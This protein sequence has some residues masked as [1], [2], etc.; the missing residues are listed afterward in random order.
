MVRASVVSIFTV[1]IAMLL[2]GC[3]S[4]S[5]QPS[6]PTANQKQTAS[7]TAATGGNVWRMKKA[8][9]HTQI[10]WDPMPQWGIDGRPIQQ[11]VAMSMMVPTD[12]TFQGGPVDLGPPDCNLNTGRL[13]FVAFSPDK[14]TG[15]VS[16]PAIASVWSNDQRVLQVIAANNQQFQKMQ[17]CKIEQPGPLANKIAGIAQAMGGNGVQI[18][19][20]MEPIPGTAEKLA[21]LVQKANANL[22][23]QAAQTGAPAA[24]LVV[25]AGR[26]LTRGKDESGQPSEGYVA[27]MQVT[28]VDTLA[29]G[30]TFWTTDY[31]MQVATFAPAGM[32]AG[33][34]RMFSAMLDSVWVNPVYQES[35]AEVS[36]NLLRIQ[37]LTKQRLNQIAANM[38]ADNANAARQQQAI[39]MG[40]QNYAN[41]VHSNVAA[42]RSAALEHSSQQFSMYMGDQA[43]YHDPS[44][45]QNVQLSSQYGH[46]WA[47]NTGNTNEYILTDSP[48]YNPN[49]QVGSGSWTQ[50][51][52]V[53]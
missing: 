50:M 29:N 41:Q 32:L 13:G 34:D 28:R 43:M 49:G 45:G 2:S 10:G 27:V 42:N 15:I 51:Q 24:H 39:R 36:G 5:G 6:D 38:A 11:V 30:A 48:S 37:T 17:Q 21:G 47:S 8:E 14:K 4:G 25:E 7:G 16:R 12:W 35:M 22:A 33:N 20:A 44:T 40:V 53:R 46:V 19:G 1:S 18:A 26:I 9:A 31:P 52:Q 3:R 23:Q